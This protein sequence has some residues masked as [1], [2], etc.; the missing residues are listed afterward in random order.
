[1]YV[2]RMRM[3][4]LFFYIFSSPRNPAATLP[5]IESEVVMERFPIFVMEPLQ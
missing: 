2:Y 4:Q 1:M 3:K 5:V